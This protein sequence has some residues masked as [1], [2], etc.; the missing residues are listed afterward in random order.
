VVCTK[1]AVQSGQIPIQFSIHHDCANLEGGLSDPLSEE[2]MREF[3]AIDWNCRSI[4]A[5][6]F[7]SKTGQSWEDICEIDSE[8]ATA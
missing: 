4:E 7:L 3:A 2:Q 1:R 5:H 6:V 8:I